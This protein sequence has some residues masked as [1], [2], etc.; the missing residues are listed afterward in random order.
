MEENENINNFSETVDNKIPEGTEYD[1]FSENA[2]KNVIEAEN[3][4]RDYL[5]HIYKEDMN[6]LNREVRMTRMQ[7]LREIDKLNAYYKSEKKNYKKHIIFISIVLIIFAGAGIWALREWFL[8]TQFYKALY[9]EVAYGRISMSSSEMKGFLLM[10]TFY[11]TI[12]VAFVLVGICQFAFFGYGYYKK[13][14]H[15]EKYKK[16]SLDSLE[17]RKKE[18]MLLGHYDSVR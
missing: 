4:N 17:V 1:I 2:P 10:T 7:Y 5:K 12:G 3:M 15:L 13:I 11:G 18:A 16:M 6:F 8:L 14:R 9:G